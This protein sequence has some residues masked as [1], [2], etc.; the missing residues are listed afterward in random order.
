VLA[1]RHGGRVVGEHQPHSL[2]LDLDD[3]RERR[4]QH[5]TP[6]QSRGDDEVSLPDLLDDAD[7]ATRAPDVESLA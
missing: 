5:S 2:G 1:N 4:H 7:A 3:A 6:E